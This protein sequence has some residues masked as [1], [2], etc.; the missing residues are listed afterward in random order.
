MIFKDIISNPFK[1][2][3]NKF[4]TNF[5]LDDT[6]EINFNFENLNKSLKL[7]NNFLESQKSYIHKTCVIEKNVEM[8]GNIYLDEGVKVFID[9]KS[10]IYL[11]DTEL[12]FQDG[13][14]GKGFV[15]SNPNADRTCGCGESFSVLIKI[16]QNG[17]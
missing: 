8:E 9:P 17:Y 16:T 10:A 3:K 5:V 15:F 11:K 1:I 13:L 6:K 12:D 2:G 7:V 4:I 14:N